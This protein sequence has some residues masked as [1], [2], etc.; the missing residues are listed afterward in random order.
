MKARTRFAARPEA[1]RREHRLEVGQE[2]ELT[3]DALRGVS[4]VL[5]AFHGKDRCLVEVGILERG[6]LLNLPHQ[7]VR[8]RFGP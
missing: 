2:V 8:S 6:V 3:L 7:A 4:G 5:L 1:K